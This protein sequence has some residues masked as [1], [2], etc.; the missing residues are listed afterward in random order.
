MNPTTDWTAFDWAAWTP[1]EKATLMFLRRDDEVLLIHKKRGLGT[2]KVNGPGGRLEPGEDFAQAAVRETEE[3]VGLKVS[4]LKEIA[5]LSFVF[6]D[7][8]S[9]YARVF[10]A[11]HFTGTPTETDEA[12]PFWC[13]IAD[14]PWDKM[15][16]DDPL[17][18]KPCLEN[19]L[20][21]VGRFI[22][23]GDTMLTQ[24]VGFRPLT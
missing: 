15:W 4:G 3:E 7:G 22:F 14:I 11:D 10:Q 1:R 19:S 17:W 8:Y 24:D 5:E 2:G 16:A 12:D 18:L 21:A 9:L 6:V 20:Y 13:R 23:D